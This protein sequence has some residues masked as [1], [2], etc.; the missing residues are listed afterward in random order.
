MIRHLTDLTIRSL[1]TLRRQEYFW[2]ATIPG[3][4]V[5]V[6][7][8]GTKTFV[9]QQFNRRHTL[10]R[11]PYMTLKAARD[12]AYKR[13][14]LK[15]LPPPS[16]PASELIRRYLD[17][18]QHNVKASSLAQI[19]LRLR[20]FP[21]Q[22][23]RTITAR[24]LL[25][26]LTPLAPGHQNVVFANFKTFLNWC[27]ENDYLVSNPL[28]NKRTPNKRTSRERLLTD[29][30]V[31]AIWLAC[32]DHQN[33]GIIVRLLIVSGQRL[34]QICALQ[35]DWIDRESDTITF[36]PSIMKNSLQHI[37]PFSLCMDIRS[38]SLSNGS[39]TMMLLAPQRMAR[40]QPARTALDCAPQPILSREIAVQLRIAWAIASPAVA[41]VA[42]PNAPSG[43]AVATVQS[44][45]RDVGAIA[46][47]SRC[48]PISWADSAPAPI[49]PRDAIR[50]AR[51]RDISGM[52][53]LVDLLSEIGPE[54]APPSHSNFEQQVGKFTWHR[55]ERQVGRRQLAIA[56]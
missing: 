7:K 43:A 8:A 11:Y 35:S 36:P 40:I 32:A 18:K 2:C 29:E 41:A 37:I 39:A 33:F 51:K 16:L 38:A 1:S 21:N 19:E 20:H 22:P 48:L 10:G 31:R 44:P 53:I 23:V 56:P 12:E 4:G 5:C 55:D 25:D 24:Q 42:T 28:Q 34:A 54:R 9:F 26:A 49:T 3:L 52:G 13:I 50:L 17:T 30:E 6:S 46:L 14:A 27:V 47:D 15:Y 45:P